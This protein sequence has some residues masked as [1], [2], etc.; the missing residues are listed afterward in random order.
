MMGPSQ[1][2]ILDETWVDT[3]HWWNHTWN[4]DGVETVGSS[5][6]SGDAC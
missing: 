3:R 4:C 6:V 1:C 2:G 5:C